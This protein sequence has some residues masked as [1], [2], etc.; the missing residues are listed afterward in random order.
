MCSAALISSSACATGFHR[1]SPARTAAWPAPVENQEREYTRQE[2]A[3]ANDSTAHERWRS[4]ARWSSPSPRAHLPPPCRPWVADPRGQLHLGIQRERQTDR[5]TDTQTHRHTDTQKH[6]RTDTQAEHGE[7]TQRHRNT[8]RDTDRDT[9]T[10]I[11]TADTQRHRH[12][13]TQTQGHTDRAW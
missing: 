12:T 4:P 1:L 3:P 8:D 11:H 6:R 13:D 5:D 2:L 7:E 9:E 10:H